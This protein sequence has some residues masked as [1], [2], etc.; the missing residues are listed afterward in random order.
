VAT[1]VTDVAT[2]S[3]YP[4]GVV[5]KFRWETDGA[6]GLLRAMHGLATDR[7]ARE[8]LGRAAWDYVERHHDWSRVVRQYVEVIDRCHDELDSPRRRAGL[9]VAL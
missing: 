7:A 3:D 8:A 6:D 1:V 4:E 5:R 9:T 2:F